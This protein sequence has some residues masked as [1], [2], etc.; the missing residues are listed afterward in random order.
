MCLDFHTSIDGIAIKSRQQH[1]Q[2]M[3]EPDSHAYIPTY[4]EP[5]GFDVVLVLKRG[6]TKIRAQ[7][8]MQML[9]LFSGVKTCDRLTTVTLD[10]NQFDGD[11]PEQDALR[12]A[13]EFT[14]FEG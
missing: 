3:Y 14:L 2:T 4:H 7:F 8:N 9:S 10:A 11:V 5:F 6:M 13:V 1:I 12:V